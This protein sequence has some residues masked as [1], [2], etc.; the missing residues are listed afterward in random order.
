MFPRRGLRYGAAMPLAK[1]RSGSGITVPGNTGVK[2]VKAVTIRAPAAELYRFWRNFSNLSQIIRHPVKITVL[3]ETES[4][5][6]VSA[7]FSDKKVTWRATV[8]NDKPPGLIAWRSDPEAE[9]P[10]AG[11][12]RFEKAPGDE[13]TEVTVALEYDAPGGK[14]GAVLAK[15]SPDAPSHQVA[16]T[17]RRLKA[18]VE[19]G[20][21]PT[22]EGQPV[23]EPQRSKRK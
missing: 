9:V 16:D 3:S 20:E 1:K 22:I 21:I 10:N 5:W 7:P 13:G 23:G 2:I 15:L 6:S 4:E 11:S 19:A 8:I 18:L 14:V 12:V 17:L